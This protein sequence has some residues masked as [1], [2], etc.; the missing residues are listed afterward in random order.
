M[1]RSV[2]VATPALIF[3]PRS[4]PVAAFVRAWEHKRSVTTRAQACLGRP[5]YSVV[6][7]RERGIASAQEVTEVMRQ[8]T[9]DLL[10]PAATRTTSC[11]GD[12]KVCTII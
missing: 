1:R 2:R 7:V 8:S 12:P 4:R 3:L 5:D 11:P 10:W 6:R 9:D